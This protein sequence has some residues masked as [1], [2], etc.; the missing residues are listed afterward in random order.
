MRKIQAHKTHRTR[1]TE[2]Y[3]VHPVCATSTTNHQSFL[4]IIQEKMKRQNLQQIHCNILCS[5]SQSPS[6]FL[7]PRIHTYCIAAIQCPHKSEG[8]PSRE[9]NPNLNITSTV[10]SF[11]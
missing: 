11:V 3:V 2:I 6:L 7:A 5:L 8:L 9:K 1:E 10:R 4:S